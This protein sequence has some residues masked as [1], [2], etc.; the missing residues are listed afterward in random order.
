MSDIE[1]A[2]KIPDH[3]YK[4]L[5]EF[6]SDS[7]E[8]NIENVLTKAVEHGAPLPKGHWI[9]TNDDSF[10]YHRIYKCSYCGNTVCDIPKNIQKYKYCS[11]CGSRNEVEE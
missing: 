7:N 9:D 11:N 6:P 10:F 1:L 2:I 8:A 3:L 4:L 5:K